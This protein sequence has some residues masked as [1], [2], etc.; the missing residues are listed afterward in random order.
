LRSCSYPSVLRRR[1]STS[2]GNLGSFCFQVCLS[3]IR[4]RDGMVDVLLRERSWAGSDFRPEDSLFALG[5]RLG[6]ILFFFILIILIIV[7]V[8]IS[9]PCISSWITN[10]RVVLGR[11][12]DPVE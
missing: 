1:R 11:R 8:G 4:L 5:I 7:L 6:V 10:R 2:Y 9:T 3:E 12:N